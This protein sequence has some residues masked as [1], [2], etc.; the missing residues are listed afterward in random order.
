MNKSEKTIQFM[1][2]AGRC[3]NVVV[4]LCFEHASNTHNYHIIIT[5]KYACHNILYLYSNHN[6]FSCIQV[7]GDYAKSIL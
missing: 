1:L 5:I 2:M 3:S 6:V 4:L 7:I